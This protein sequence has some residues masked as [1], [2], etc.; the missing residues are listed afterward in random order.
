MGADDPPWIFFLATLEMFS[1]NVEQADALLERCLS[2]RPDYASAHWTLAK[3]R[4][5]NATDNHIDRLLAQLRMRKEQDSGVPYLLSAL[6]KELD[7]IGETRD[8]W[9]ALVHGSLAWRRTVEYDLRRETEGFAALARAFP[10]PE[11]TNKP[12]PANTCTPIFIVGLPRSGTTL[13]ERVLGA[14]TDVHASGE[15]D[16]MS[17]T[18]V[19]AS[20]SNH[21]FDVPHEAASLRLAQADHATIAQRYLRNTSWRRGNRTHYTDK[22]PNNF[23][24]V[25]SIARAMPWA[26]I[27]HVHK[28]PM[29]GCFSLL[30]EFFGG[31]YNYSYRLNELA[32]YHDGY[33]GLMQHWRNSGFRF[34][35]V[36]YEKFVQEPEP[37]A[38]RILAYCGLDWQEQCLHTDKAEG[39][40]AS[41]SVVQAREPV[42]SRYVASWKQYESELEPLQRM[43]GGS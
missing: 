10:Y 14:H 24:H 43:L 4:R 32:A 26:K 22:R 42:S 36:S 38:R 27:I 33:R 11:R 30:K 39:A 1:G 29:D 13:I 16:D 8:A 7:D 37:E 9:R 6:F 15:L 12:E 31:R 28:Q 2:E 34:L 23:I 41:A 35:D 19:H 20:G 3:L 5:Y 25:A 17:A 21:Y 40:I 18:V